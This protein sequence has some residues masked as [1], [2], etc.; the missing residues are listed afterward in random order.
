MTTNSEVRA[1]IHLPYEITEAR[2]GLHERRRNALLSLV[3]FAAQHDKVAPGDFRILDVGC[4]RGEFMRH[5]RSKGFETEGVDLDPECV[6]ISQQYGPCQQSTVE[7]L[8]EKYDENAFD[9]IVASHV[10]EHTLSPLDA[11]QCL[12]RASNKWLVLAVPNPVRPHILL[13][14]IMRKRYSNQ[15]H[16]VA[17]DR[18]HFHNFLTEYAQL[19]IEK[20]QTDHVRLVSHSLMQKGVGRFSFGLVDYVEIKLLTRLFPF[21][22]DSL[23]ALCRVKSAPI[24]GE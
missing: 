13:K 22:S 14:N 7:E 2:A 8:P 11:V 19:E 18:S 4:G 15:G 1:G 24:Q 5:L 17:W 23:I 20:W 16:V 21:F 12:A 9:L 6:A 3:E 10:L